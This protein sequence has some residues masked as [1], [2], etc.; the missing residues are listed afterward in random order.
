MLT[1]DYLTLR[2]VRL[3]QSEEWV[4]EPQRLTFIFPN[5]GSGKFVAGSVAHR[6]APGDVLAA[7]TAAGTGSG[8]ITWA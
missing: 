6:L 3:K 7:N 8:G 4:C 5:G 2:L 1:Q